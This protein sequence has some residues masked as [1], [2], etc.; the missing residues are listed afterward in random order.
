MEFNGRMYKNYKAGD[1]KEIVVHNT[2]IMDFV[3]TSAC[4]EARRRPI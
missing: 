3:T 2:S 1:K 4:K